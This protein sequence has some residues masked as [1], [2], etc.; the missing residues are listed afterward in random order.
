MYS[1]IA[2]SSF[3]SGNR[4]A[5]AIDAHAP[6]VG[7]RLVRETH[8]ST[9]HS[10]TYLS[11]LSDPSLDPFANWLDPNDEKAKVYPAK[12][13]MILK[14][15]PDLMS[16]QSAA[17]DWQSLRSP[18]GN[19]Y[20]WIGWLCRDDEGNWECRHSGSDSDDGELVVIRKSA[21]EGAV[22]VD[23]VGSLQ[24]RTFN[25]SASSSDALLEGRPVFLVLPVTAADK[26]P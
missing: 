14:D 15:L 25:I 6:D 10:R 17:Q 9:G 1:L 5:S 21:G 18:V 13:E 24:H 11:T 3:Q 20:R 7:R 19:R 26:R 16:L 22:Q 8:H 12:A 4:S 23:T 2:E